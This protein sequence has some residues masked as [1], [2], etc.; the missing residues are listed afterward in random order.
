MLDAVMSV[1]APATL[2]AELQDLEVQIAKLTAEVEDLRLAAAH[3][4]LAAGASVDPA[5]DQRV[6]EMCRL[7]D[8][9]VNELRALRM[10]RRAINER[11]RPATPAR[12]AL[13]SVEEP[14]PL[15]RA[16]KRLTAARE[17]RAAMIVAARADERPDAPRRL[18]QAFDEVE[19]EIVQAR[20]EVR[21]ARVPH[22][23]AV[24]AA[25]APIVRTSAEAAL[26]A[27]RQLLS[28]L[29]T[30]TE[31]ASYMPAVDGVGNPLG[32]IA[33]INTGPIRALE[34]Y[35]SALVDGQL[36]DQQAAQE[37]AA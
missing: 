19:A 22:D 30:L 21:K 34:E 10:R 18:R 32:G 15:V 9:R 16:K 29:E 2:V 25:L 37:D 5:R 3:E 35:A 7:K 33:Y 24:R 8:A 31:A 13:I 20:A 23:R 36:D 11:L 4:V 14:A 27:T 17:K 6:R 26:A 28:E 1:I 12:A